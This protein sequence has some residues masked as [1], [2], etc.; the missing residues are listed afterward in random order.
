MDLL[1]TT[2]LYLRRIPKGESRK[3]KV[4]AK[5]DPDLLIKLTKN[6]IDIGFSEFEFNSDYTEIRRMHTKKDYFS[7][8]YLKKE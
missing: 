8:G 7:L 6:L 4:I 1:Y 2:L 5:K 3:I